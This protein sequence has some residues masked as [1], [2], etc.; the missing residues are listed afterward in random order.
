MTKIH[1]WNQNHVAYFREHSLL[2]IK[3]IAVI[4]LTIEIILLPTSFMLDE[5]FGCRP[6][7]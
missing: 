3:F 1:S 5:K 7:S 2:L 6:D 4:S